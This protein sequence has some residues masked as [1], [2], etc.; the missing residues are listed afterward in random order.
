M[1]H[2]V[3]FSGGLGSWAAAK[4]VAEIHGTSNL[5]L[6]FCDT[7]TEDEDL[8]RFLDE[9]A[10]NV[11]VPVTRI[12]DGRDVWQV[13][14]DERFLGNSKRDPCSKILKRELIDRWIAA[15]FTPE[16][17]I[18]NTGIDWTEQH[19]MFGRNGKPGLAE[20]L[21]PWSVEAP[22]CN[23]PLMSKPQIRDWLDREGI[24]AP[25]LYDMGFPHNNCGGFC[26]KAG[27][28]Q[29]RLLLEKIPD[30]Y[31]Y[32]ERREQELRDYLQKDVSILRDRRGGTSKPLTLRDFRLRI[33]EEERGGLFPPDD[34]EWGACGC[35]VESD[36]DVLELLEV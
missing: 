5:I 9:A 17:C 27:H 3:Q 2:I 36:D 1:K 28:A 14:F 15:R 22:L 21:H 26:I 11:G 8:Y 10:A 23:R 18:R 31:A 12:E 4:R 13:F 29:F 25:R 32:H 19:R 6:L 24:K 35:F 7:K 34:E 30:R 20:R 33:E 16:T